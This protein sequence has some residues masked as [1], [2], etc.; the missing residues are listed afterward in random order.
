MAA[1]A[2]TQPTFASP[3]KGAA[4]PAGDPVMTG[5]RL[6]AF[7]AGCLGTATSQKAG[8]KLGLM[9]SAS[10]EEFAHIL[11]HL[12][13]LA[14]QRAAKL[15]GVSGMQSM[16]AQAGMCSTAFLTALCKACG[17]PPDATG[18]FEELPHDG[19]GRADLLRAFEMNGSAVQMSGTPEA[20][21]A[22]N[23]ERIDGKQEVDP[24]LMEYVEN[25][26]DL[27]QVTAAATAS[28]RRQL[29]DSG[30]LEA[31]WTLDVAAVNTIRAA[32]A[33]GIE[34]DVDSESSMGAAVIRTIASRC[35]SRRPALA[36]CALRALMELAQCSKDVPEGRDTSV[37]RDSPWA[38]AA[39]DVVSSCLG[40]LRGTKVVARVAES[41]LTSVVKRIAA[42][43]SLLA[44][45]EAL[46][47]STASAVGT[48]PPQPAVVSAGL[49][50]LVPLLPGLARAPGWADNG[51]GKTVS[52]CTSLCEDVLNN[53]MLGTAFS[54]ARA[55]QR[56][57]QSLPQV[58]APEASPGKAKCSTQGSCAENEEAAET[59]AEPTS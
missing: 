22:S 40:A 30:D 1:G 25:A 23:G 55:A 48:K 20:D 47:H 45:V 26:S 21:M 52:A 2:D 44:A 41:T 46:M 49:K 12:E 11:R 9:G 53:K 4:W 32:L 7:A 38:G 51:A 27:P 15:A 57:L 35:G 37:T 18:L 31:T 36:K 17:V 33:H 29:A 28:A 39:Q 24:I 14:R 43:V 13:T 50:A 34:E 19:G 5:T 6:A 56:A 42:D 58:K 3:L 8:E 59:K 54:D 16:P 10:E